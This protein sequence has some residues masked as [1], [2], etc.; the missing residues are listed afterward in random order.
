MPPIRLISFGY[1]HLGGGSPPAADR[2]E[3]VRERLRDPARARAVLDLDGFDPRV[4]EVVLGTPGAR[5]LLD[6]L[7]EYALLDGS[8]GIAIGCAG[9][10]HRACALVEIL[11]GMVRGR[12]RAVEV[13]HLH[14]HLPR[15][16]D[17][18]GGEAGR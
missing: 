15:V 6:N 12:G 17:P 2:V 18:A 10:R 4:Q 16:L 8:S 9:G 13:L 14:A 3:D 1:L 11:S 7:G 5:E